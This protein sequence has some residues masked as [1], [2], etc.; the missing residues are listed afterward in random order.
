MMGDCVAAEIGKC[1]GCRVLTTAA[2]GLSVGG[3]GASGYTRPPWEWRDMCGSEVPRA[4][5]VGHR[6]AIR[7]G[8]RL[9]LGFP[10]CYVKV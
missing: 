4:A 6:S 3:N 10:C 5:L 2:R 1:W 9:F 7:G 8:E